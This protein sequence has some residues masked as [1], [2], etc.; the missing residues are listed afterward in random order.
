ML[1]GLFDPALSDHVT[2]GVRRA[3]LVDLLSGDGARRPDD[4][5]AQLGRERT[6]GPERVEDGA[7]HGI[8]HRLQLFIACLAE[9]D[10][11]DEPGRV[12]HR[13]QLGSLDLRGGGAG[14]QQRGREG[15]GVG[16]A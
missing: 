2:G 8:D 13:G 12:G 3:E 1:V 6:A 7:R 10:H 14:L 16:H 15:V 5:G 11:G 4:V 9:R